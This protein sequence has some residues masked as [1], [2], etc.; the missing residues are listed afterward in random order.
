MAQK[1]LIV[2]D[3]VDIAELICYQLAKEGYQT[4]VAPDGKVAL[5]KLQS[6]TF[7]CIILD[8]MLPYIDGLEVLKRM[9][10]SLNIQTPVIIASAKGEEQDIITGLE[11]G[12]DDYLAKPFSQK[13]LMAK[14]KSLLRRV[15][16]IKSEAKSVNTDNLTIDESRHTCLCQGKNIELTATEFSLLQTLA[17]EEGRVFTRGQLINAVKGNDYPVTE[18]SIDVQ[19]ATIRRKLG[20]WGSSLRTVWGVGYKYQEQEE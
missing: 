1:L 6:E 16:G 5:E 15:N 19:I 2:E 7:D 12:A 18:R 13:V 4:T 10:Y 3:E 17:Q 8:I 11:L 20:D 9:R 14:V